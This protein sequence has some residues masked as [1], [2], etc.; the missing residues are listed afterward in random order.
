MKTA[1]VIIDCDNNGRGISSNVTTD[2][3]RESHFYRVGATAKFLPTATY[4]SQ[5]LFLSF[6]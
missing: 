1:I 3:G 2:D 6:T 5:P 4:P